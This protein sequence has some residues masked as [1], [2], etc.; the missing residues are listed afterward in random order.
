MRTDEAGVIT[1]FALV[2][3]TKLQFGSVL[4]SAY[5]PVS[6]IDVVYDRDTVRI[7]AS[8]E[9]PSLRIAALGRVNVSVNGEPPRRIITQD[10]ML[11]PFEERSKF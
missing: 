1:G 5:H 7:T 8:E 6:G 10:G 9:H 3:G 2:Y 11:L 4:V